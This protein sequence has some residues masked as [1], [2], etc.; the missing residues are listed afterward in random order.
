[1]CFGLGVLRGGLE[2]VLDL[3]IGFAKQQCGKWSLAKSI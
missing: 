1:M 2:I 3:S